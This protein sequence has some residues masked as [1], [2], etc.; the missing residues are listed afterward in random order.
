MDTSRVHAGRWFLRPGRLAAVSERPCGI[1]EGSTS[2]GGAVSR[3]CEVVKGFGLVGVGGLMMV[4]FVAA[5][6]RCWKNTRSH[7]L[8]A[9]G[10][11][12]VL[13]LIHLILSYV[14]LRQEKIAEN[15][16][17]SYLILSDG[18]RLRDYT[19]LGNG[20]ARACA[21][22]VLCCVRHMPL[23]AIQTNPPPASS[24]SLHPRLPAA[25]LVPV[26]CDVER[27][28]HANHSRVWRL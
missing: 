13:N 14:T 12:P 21:G 24:A 4:D 26:P 22:V 20:G 2:A 10:A 25:R 16:A 1:L 19:L 27:V 8:A 5:E 18:R 15:H 9:N 17:Q 7:V 11:R 3:C 23:L 28:R 6:H